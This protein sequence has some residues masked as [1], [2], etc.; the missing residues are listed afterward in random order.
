MFL[1]GASLSEEAGNVAFDGFLLD[2]NVLFERF[3]TR[4][5]RER[6]VS[7]LSLRDQFHLTLDVGAQVQMRPDLVVSNG[8]SPVLVAD[9]KYKR[10]ETGQHKNHDLYQLVSYCTA[11]EVGKGMLI[12]PRHL[13]DIATAMGIRGADISIHEITIDFGGSLADIDRELDAFAGRVLDFSQPA[14]LDVGS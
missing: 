8:T 9:C 5:L 14:G 1:E 7:P 12:Y 3:I 11:L 2:M 10:L 4:S 13:V 6:L